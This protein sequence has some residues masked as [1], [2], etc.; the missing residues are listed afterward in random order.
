MVCGSQCSKMRRQWKSCEYLVILLDWKPC[1]GPR[2]LAL[3]PGFTDKD[4]S[5]RWEALFFSGQMSTQCNTTWSSAKPSFFRNHLGR[6]SVGLVANT[7]WRV[8]GRPSV[9][10]PCHPCRHR[11][12]AE[13]HSSAHV[14]GSHQGWSMSVT[15][16]CL[17]H[18]I[19]CSSHPE[20]ALGC[21]AE[22]DDVK[23]MFI[24]SYK[25]PLSQLDPRNRNVC[26]FT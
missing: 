2:W 7:L 11:Q 25:L 6:L 19:L 17:Q 18:T 13:K 23:K 24:L 9:A 22:V 5:K 15:P 14:L 4:K 1:G 21:P 12:C 26:V 3:D 20:N 8:W 10:H 16:Y